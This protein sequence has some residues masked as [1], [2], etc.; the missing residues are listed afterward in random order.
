[1]LEHNKITIIGHRGSGSNKFQKLWPENTIES[2]QN[3]FAQGAGEVEFDLSLSKDG[4]VF[5]FHDSFIRTGFLDKLQVRE[6]EYSEIKKLRRQVSEFSEVLDKL[7]ERTF[8]IEL[9]SYTNYKYIFELLNEK[10][11]NKSNIKHFRFISFTMDALKYIKQINPEIYC[12]F[13]GTCVDQRFDPF[14]SNK[15][16]EL[17]KENKIDEISGHWFGF[18]PKMINRAR[19]AGLE[20]GIGAVNTPGAFYYC[21]KNGVKRIYTDNIRGL[22]R[23]VKSDG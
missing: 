5:I 22:V 19:Q 20:V 2:F 14:I 13:I 21:Q 12:I 17:V 1:M 9:K 18:R 11:I 10:Y 15:L 16:L 7:P 23:L 6:L 4:K 3:A 8:V